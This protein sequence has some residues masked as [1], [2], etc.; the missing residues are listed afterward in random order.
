M[1]ESY[2]KKQSIVDLGCGSG[3]LSIILKENGGFLNNK[4][5]KKQIIGFDHCE[6]AI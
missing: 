5:D 3:I 1:K 6:N 4:N 2:S